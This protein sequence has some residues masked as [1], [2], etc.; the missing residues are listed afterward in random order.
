[1]L[2]ILAQ[3]QSGSLVGGAGCRRAMTIEYIE[4][5]STCETRKKSFLP[6]Q[7]AQNQ[8][9]W[10]WCRR[11]RPLQVP[12]LPRPQPPPLVAACPGAARDGEELLQR[13][14]HSAGVSE[15]VFCCCCLSSCPI[16]NRQ[17][18]ASETVRR[19]AAAQSRPRSMKITFRLG[20]GRT[21]AG[22]TMVAGKCRTLERTFSILQGRGIKSE[23]HVRAWRC[24]VARA[25]VYLSHH[26]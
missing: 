24:C 25:F 14:A 4:F 18:A 17:T 12:M 9:M 2:S 3:S 13:Q 7:R 8:E 15:N 1:M 22:S 5:R 11:P 20:T 10:P 16:R 21:P 6:R 26:M 23:P 19:R